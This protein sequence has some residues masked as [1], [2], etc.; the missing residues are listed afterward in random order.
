MAH[1]VQYCFDGAVEMGDMTADV[2]A[3]FHYFHPNPNKWFDETDTATRSGEP[4][5]LFQ[6][7]AQ[8]TYIAARPT[9]TPQQRAV[10]SYEGLLNLRTQCQETAREVVGA[11]LYQIPEGG[12]TPRVMRRLTAPSFLR[13][14]A[15]RDQL[16]ETRRTRAKALIVRSLE[17][18]RAVKGGKEIADWINAEREKRRAEDAAVLE[19]I[20]LTIE[21]PIVTNAEWRDAYDTAARERKKLQRLRQR[22]MKQSRK[23]AHR[24]FKLL[25][26]VTSHEKARMFLG[27]DYVSIDGQR[28]RFVMKKQYSLTTTGHGGLEIQIANK[29]GAHLSNLCLYFE[30]TPAVDQVAAIAMHVAAGEEDD[31]IRTGNLYNLQPGAENNMALTTLK[32]QKFEPSRRELRD[33]G[34]MIPPYMRKRGDEE[35]RDTVRQAAVPICE[36]IVLELIDPRLLRFKEYPLLAG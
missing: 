32:P 34:F 7:R 12:L 31:M 24:G 28:F 19:H 25:A 26:S 6:N 17:D 9:M 3:Y 11:I 23:A 13:R 15:K 4:D 18:T 30:G 33:I 29:A 21:K 8:A 35:Q 20:R 36:R 22:H 27:G 2:A 14:C 1:D 16:H 5:T 10:C